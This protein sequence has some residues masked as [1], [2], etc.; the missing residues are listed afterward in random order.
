MIHIGGQLPSL[1]AA[2]DGRADPR[3]VTPYSG[4]LSPGGHTI[5]FTKDGYN[6]ETRT[7]RVTAGKTSYLYALCRPC[8]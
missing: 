1:L 5:I 3:W 8:H 4:K 7:G 6:A 2:L